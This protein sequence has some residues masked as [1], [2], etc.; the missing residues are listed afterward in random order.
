MA[1][2]RTGALALGPRG[3]GCGRNCSGRDRGKNAPKERRPRSAADAPRGLIAADLELVWTIERQ[4]SRTELA[5]KADV[6]AELVLRHAN[7]GVFKAA[8]S[9]ATRRA[10]C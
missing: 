9:R 1:L 3:R 6:A 4:R 8:E 7:G 2:L 10:I 5:E